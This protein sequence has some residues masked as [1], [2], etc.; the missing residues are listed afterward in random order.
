[1]NDKPKYLPK[2]WERFNQELRGY[3]YEDPVLFEQMTNEE[4]EADLRA[5]GVDP[6]S[7]DAL[8]MKILAEAEQRRP[9]NWLQTTRAKVVSIWSKVI[10]LSQVEDERNEEFVC[11]PGPLSNGSRK[12]IRT[13]TIVVP[14]AL[15]KRSPWVGEKLRIMAKPSQEDS[16]KNIFLVS[17]EVRQNAVKTGELTVAIKFKSDNKPVIL[18]LKPREPS[19]SIGPLPDNLNELEIQ[20]LY[21]PCM[22]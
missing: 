18:L 1:M 6:N 3:V 4:A 10:D 11:A 2:E 19:A 12:H 17:V 21:C 9:A 7:L 20:L 16:Q 8:K 22:T 14:D 15:R 13:K 5:R